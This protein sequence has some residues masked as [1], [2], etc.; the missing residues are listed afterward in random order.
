[1]RDLQR[2]V[3]QIEDERLASDPKEAKRLE[4][5]RAALADEGLNLDGLIDERGVVVIPSDPDGYSRGLRA[6]ARV[7]GFEF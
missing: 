2:R 7:Q 4:R 1:M 6:M 5:M 3:R